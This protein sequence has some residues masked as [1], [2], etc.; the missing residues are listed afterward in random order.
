M[1]SLRDLLNEINLLRRNP[2]GYAEK[3]LKYKSYFDGNILRIPGYKGGIQT[4]EGPSA[5][6]EA[7]N[8]LLS[9]EPVVEMTPSKGLTGIA[10]DLLS[11][12]QNCEPDEIDN[13]DMNEIIEKYG[14][15]SGNFSRSMEFGGE[16]A[17]QVIMNLIVNDGDKSR[18]QRDSLLDGNLKVVGLAS[19]KH[20]YF[21]NCS[22]IVSSTTFN[23]IQS[24]NDDENY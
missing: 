8:F 16:N 5:Y 21:G 2:K 14:S 7:A 3:V 17:E 13:I 20:E 22:I 15:F 11:S 24:K 4:E 18:S 10:N 1:S 23:N 19:G 6:A 12:V 9:S